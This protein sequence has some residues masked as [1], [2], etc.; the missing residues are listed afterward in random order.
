MVVL[1]EASFSAFTSNILVSCTHNVKGNLAKLLLKSK[2]TACVTNNVKDGLIPSEQWQ[3]V[4]MHKTS[5]LEVVHLN[6]V[7]LSLK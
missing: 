5:V 1:L 6:I 4:S 2:K 3:W 7:Q